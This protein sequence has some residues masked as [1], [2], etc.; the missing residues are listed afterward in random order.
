MTNLNYFVLGFV[1][2]FSVELAFAGGKH[3][4]ATTENTYIDNTY[5]NEFEY[6]SAALATA[7]GQHQFDFGTRQLQGALGYGY[8]DG[9][10][11]LSG[12]I[13]KQFDDELLIHGTIGCSTSGDVCGGGAGI[14]IRF[15]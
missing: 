3:H 9:R 13:A 7:L 15:D 6:D 14:T 12:A 2:M 4:H 10:S 5:I 1:L 11:A 8:I